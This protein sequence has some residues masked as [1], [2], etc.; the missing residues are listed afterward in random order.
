MVRN[1][2]PSNPYTAFSVGA[3]SPNEWLLGAVMLQH[4]WAAHVQKV[5]VAF[6]TTLFPGEPICHAEY[7]TGMDPC[8]LCFW[9]LAGWIL[10][11][12]IIAAAFWNIQRGIMC[13]EV[14]QRV[15]RAQ[16]APSPGK[17]SAGKQA[18]GPHVEQMT[19]EKVQ[20][21]RRC[22]PCTRPRGRLSDS[23]RQGYF[24][25]QKSIVH[26]ISKSADMLCVLHYL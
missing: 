11:G 18:V 25:R 7:N 10:P 12:V 9:P 21:P 8:S 1:V 13:H 5:V 20:S 26:L 22:C 3:I 16:I 4:L 23:A 15:R 24:T 6:M 2:I 17:E 19:V 14:I